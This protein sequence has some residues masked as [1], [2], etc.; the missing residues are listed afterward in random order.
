M[1]RLP[2]EFD[3]QKAFTIWYKGEKRKDG[4]WKTIPAQ[5]PGVVAWHTP[6]GGERRD[7]F[8][9]MRLKESGVEAG[10]HDYLFLWGG[11]FC[12]EF[13]RPGQHQ[14]PEDGLSAAQRAMHARLL[15]AGA[16]ASATVDSLQKARETVI[17]WGL[18]VKADGDSIS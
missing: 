8:E 17:N 16:V 6:N 3:L 10:I 18:T 14:T 7:A 1:A 9:G 11:L 15:A 12:L 4:T 2:T 5:L 13:K